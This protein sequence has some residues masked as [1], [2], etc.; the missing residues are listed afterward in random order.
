MATGTFER[1]IVIDKQAWGK[2]NKKEGYVPNK[3]EINGDEEVRKRII[4]NIRKEKER[5]ITW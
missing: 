5:C 2:S 4:F 1:I 3:V